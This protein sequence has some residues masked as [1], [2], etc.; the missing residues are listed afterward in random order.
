MPVKSRVA[1][2]RATTPKMTV[3]HELFNNS[4]DQEPCNVYQSVRDTVPL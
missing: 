4:E 1:I 2:A 3:D